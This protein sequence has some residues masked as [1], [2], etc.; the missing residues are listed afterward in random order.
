MQQR[1]YESAE[2]VDP[3]VVEL[4]KARTVT[5]VITVSDSEPTEE[6]TYI[7]RERCDASPHRLDYGE[8]T[9]SII[10]LRYTI[11][12]EIALNRLPDDDPEKQ[13]YLAFV[14]AAKAAAKRVVT[15]GV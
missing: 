2:P 15:L 8:I 10:A 4:N 1:T 12:A 6:G 5:T 3:T 9:E 13:I 7:I 11:G 14:A